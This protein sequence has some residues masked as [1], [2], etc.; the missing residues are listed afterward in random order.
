MT[1]QAIDSEKAIF[2][3]PIKSMWVSGLINRIHN[4]RY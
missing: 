3:L 4:P 1:I 2:F